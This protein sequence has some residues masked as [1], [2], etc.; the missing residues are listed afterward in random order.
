MVIYKMVGQ[1]TDLMDRVTSH[2]KD[3]V[4]QLICAI[5]TEMR[6]HL[7]VLTTYCS[8]DTTSIIT[9]VENPE[10]VQFYW[11][12]VSAEFDIEDSEVHDFLL[13][14]IVELFHTI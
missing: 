10:N 6:G 5:K 13:H 14:K 7:N 2:V 1:W 9:H 3:T 8:T 11:Q 4:Y 12:T